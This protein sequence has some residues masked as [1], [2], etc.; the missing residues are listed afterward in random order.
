MVMK[1]RYGKWS[2]CL[3][4]VFM[5][6]LGIFF[7]LVRLGERGGKTFFSNLKLTIPALGAAIAAIAAFVT[8]LLAIIKKERSFFVFFST[9]TGLLVLI[10]VVLEIAFPH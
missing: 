6:L 7:L 8:G 3:I 4:L 5:A 1:T 10:Y 2:V 9:I